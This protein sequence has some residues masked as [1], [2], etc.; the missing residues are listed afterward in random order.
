MTVVIVLPP[1][2]RDG[3]EEP[4]YAHKRLGLATRVFGDEL[5]I[6]TVLKAGTFRL[7]ELQTGY[8]SAFPKSWTHC[9]WGIATRRHDLGT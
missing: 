2:R 8:L 3:T 1:A 6:P 7:D 5:D 9:C 4:P